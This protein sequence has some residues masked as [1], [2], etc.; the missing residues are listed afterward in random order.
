M[1]KTQ[2]VLVLTLAMLFLTSLGHAQS[3]QLTLDDIYDPQKRVNFSGQLPFIIK[4]L[5]DGEHYLEFN[6]NPDHG[7]LGLLKVDAT[8]GKGTPFIDSAKM[9]TAL[10]KTAGFTPEAA[11][12]NANSG[13][14]TFNST[15]SGVVLNYNS[16][17][18]YYKLGSDQA[19]RLT[20]NPEEE[21]NESFSPDGK[22]VAFVRNY[23][24]YV[25]DLATGKEQAL[26]TDGGKSIYNGRLD[27]VYEEEV[28]GRG[29][30][31]SYWW[32][33]D[34]SQ[35]AYLSLDESKV[36]SFT[37]VDDIP[38]TQKIELTSYPRAGEPN[39]TVKLKVVDAQGGENRNIELNPYQ[40]I[41][42]L[43]TRVGW[44]PD[45]HKVMFE[46]QNREQNWLDLNVA[47]SHS[48]KLENFFREESK[49]W[50][51]VVELPTFLPDGSFIWQ[52]DRTG[53]RH[54]YH[55][56][57]T[58][59]LIA[60]VTK[61]D[62]DIREVY[63]NANNWV[64]FSANEHGRICN[65][66]YRVKTDGTGFTRISQGEGQHDARFNDQFTTFIDTTSSIQ[67]PP[68]MSLYKSDGSL[69]RTVAENKVAALNEFKL[70]QPEFVRVP[71]RDGFMMD[72]V[73]IKPANFDPNKKYPIMS[74]NYS[75]PGI[76]SVKNMWG[77]ASYMWHQF[78]A[79][80]GYIIWICDNRSASQQGVRSA[81]PVYQ[82]L[83]ELELKDLEDGIS[84]LKQ[85]TYVD[86]T[87]IG[88]WGW[89]YGGYMTAYALTHS[90]SF[91]LGISG[92]PVTDWRNYDSIYTE[93]YMGLPQKNPEG[94]R[95]SSVVEAA[96]NLH[97][98]LLLIHGT[99]DDN[100]HIQNSIQF[101][102]ALQRA[103]KPFNLMLYPKSRHGVTQPLRVKHLR[104]MMTQFILE[105][106]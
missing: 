63:G 49:A 16:D 41:E 66:I 91:K 28:Y 77:G 85:Q 24:I 72:A 70:G 20:N 14:Y 64:Y 73:M 17:L 11:K 18:Y 69:V 6:R 9:E 97:G 44:T 15:H 54:L 23:N 10:T 99:L 93:R 5:D 29:V 89:S 104:T 42:F 106:L 40:S 101:V 87:R 65:D 86:G 32:S 67:H 31:T 47:D 52:S 100:V 94:Y 39:P 103:G 19:T 95:K 74:Y 105:N 82:N 78:L 62:W 7:S 58:G 88:L 2:R 12:D 60:P 38:G 68:H 3:K 35:L 59:K 36:P 33:P 1:L 92:A 48:G 53:W 56:S 57:A 61:G 84:W 55:Y 98:K 96:A 76:P 43:I 79:Q 46:V 27:W 21:T 90:T 71:T 80:Q 81:Y 83:A 75:G 25:V 8:T 22:R 26:T 30:T 51:E 13:F 4:Y 37:V 45:S 102:D 50:V 34:S